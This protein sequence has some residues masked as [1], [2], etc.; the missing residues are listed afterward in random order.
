MLTSNVDLKHITLPSRTPC[1]AFWKERERGKEEKRREEKR[2]EEERRGEE[3]RGER[4]G[5]EKRRR[6]EEEKR[7]K[8]QS[9]FK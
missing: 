2:R 6:E 9:F 7:N 1:P 8:C 4:R 3:R 5:E